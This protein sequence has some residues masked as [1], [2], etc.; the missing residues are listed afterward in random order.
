MRV[1][2]IPGRD[3][4]SPGLESTRAPGNYRALRTC[5]RRIPMPY[6]DDWVRFPRGGAQANRA[7]RR[8][9]LRQ[10]KELV[11]V[12]NNT[13]W[14]KL[15][16][17]MLALGRLPPM[18]RIMNAEYGDLTHWDGEWLHHFNLPSYAFIEWLEL[19]A[20]SPAQHEELR[21]ILRRLRLPGQETALGF[22]IA[23]YIRG[24]TPI[25]YIG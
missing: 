12:M 20:R 5:T 16:A 7:R 23:G 11:S 8:R 22:R 25:G 9:S 24:T 19:K 3:F 14:R 18:Y 10:Q 2:Q 21:G 4:A 17:A 15:R 6:S 1:G 13:R